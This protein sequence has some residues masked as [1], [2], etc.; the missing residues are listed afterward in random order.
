MVTNLRQE[1]IFAPA[2]D[3]ALSSKL[4]REASAGLVLRVRPGV[5]T[6]LIN[7]PV[8]SVVRRNWKV[9]LEHEIPGAVVSYRSALLG[10]PD[11][12]G[13]IIVSKGT[14]ARTIS[15]PGL[16][17]EVRPGTPLPGDVPYGALFVAGEMRWMLECLEAVKASASRTGPVEAIETYL[18]KVLLLRGE[19][20]LNELRDAARTFAQTYGREAEFKRLNGIIGALLNTHETHKLSSRQALA[21]ATGKP[22]D[23]DRVRLFDELFSALRQ[24][25]L[26]ELPEA[27]PTPLARDN[28]AF[29]EAYFSNYIEG[30]TFTLEEAADIIYHGAVITGRTEDTHDILGTYRAATTSPWRNEFPRSAEDF[31]HWLKSVNALVMSHRPDKL[32]GEWKTKP[33]QAGSTLFVQPE[34]VPGTLLEGFAR[35]GGLGSLLAQAFMTMFV[36]SEVHPFTDG[37]GR[38]ARLALNCALTS[39]GLSRILVPTIFRE[40]YLLPLKALSRHANPEPYIGMLSKLQRWSTALHYDQPRNDLQAQLQRCNAF[41]EARDQYRLVFPEQTQ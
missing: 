15:Y 7:V 30:T 12:A 14:R 16:T 41:E 19:H 26:P 11:D 27:T 35:I 18:D 24:T 2:A 39:A 5:Y 8:E 25:V 36:V 9:V 33:N 38:T 17:V 4:Q 29:F 21:R 31:L 28:F 23:P 34:L 6:P 22:Y 10:R 13:V 20:K 37:N 40:D 3:R 32:P 1:L